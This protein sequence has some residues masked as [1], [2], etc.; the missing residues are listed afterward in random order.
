M[1]GNQEFAMNVPSRQSLA[2]GKEKSLRL[3]LYLLL[4]MKPQLKMASKITTKRKEHS[5]IITS[6]SRMI[7]VLTPKAT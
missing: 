2:Q 5:T 6:I 7:T 4:N 3:I 1:F